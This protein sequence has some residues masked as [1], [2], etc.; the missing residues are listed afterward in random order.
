MNHIYDVIVIGVGSMG[1]ASCYYLAKSGLKVLGLEQFTL[2]H[3]KGSHTGES[4]FVRMAYFEDPDYV[5]LLK[6]AYQN[7]DH[8]EEVSGKKLFHKTGIVYFGE[9]DSAQTSGVRKSSQLY[10]LPIEIVSPKD[11]QVR[12]TPFT[13]PDHYECL[14]EPDAGFVQPELTIN[15]YVDLAT[16]HGADIKEQEKLLS[17]NQKNGIVECITD[18]GTYQAKKIVFTSGAWTQQLIPQLTG[19][20]QTTQQALLWYKPKHANQFKKDKFSCWSITDPAY[21]G[22]FYGFPLLDSPDPSFKIAYHA[23]GLDIKPEQKAKQASME[24]IE[25]LHF[26]LKTYMPSL[27][28]EIAYTKTCLYNYSPDEDFIID[29]LPDHDQ[30]VIVACGF[31]GH[32]FKF[33]PMVGELL[34]DLVV[35]GSS[36]LPVGFLGLR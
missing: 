23:H 35:A 5:P 25:P 26:F 32:G 21:D 18:K 2:P 9:T 14:F 19:T 12:F 11:S 22:M 34:K 6:R 3:E 20:L 36:D 27:E 15:C 13:I 33:V 1:S 17:W 24:E 28:G 10:N 31:S 30:S 16:H 7:W 4:R 29:F 8:L